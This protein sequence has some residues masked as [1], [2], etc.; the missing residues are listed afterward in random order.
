MQQLRIVLPNTRCNLHCRYCLAGYCNSKNET[1]NPHALNGERSNGQTE[2]PLV[3]IDALLK[4][5]KPYTFKYIGIWGGE[6]LFNRHLAPLLKAL[7][8]QYPNLSIGML[9]NGTLLNKKWVRLL[10]ELDIGLSISHDGNAQALCRCADYLTSDY[11]RLLYDLKKFKGTNS[12]VHRLNCDPWEI[13]R[14]FESKELPKTAQVNFEPFKLSDYRFIDYLPSVAEYKTFYT[15]W[16]AV[17]TAAK[18]GAEMLQSELTRARNKIKSHG[19]TSCGANNRLAV[20]LSGRIYHC[21]VAAEIDYKGAIDNS[22][23]YNCEGCIHANYC[24]GICPLISGVYRQK[25]C[26][27]YHLYFDAVREVLT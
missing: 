21:Q 9:S 5:I 14:F 1:S 25:M 12:V 13:Y 24:R 22:L 11:I 3:N 19:K 7:R 10:N 26:M 2:L 8:N 18:G 15:G 4:A 16:K 23:P 27:L 20:D 17:L 6:P